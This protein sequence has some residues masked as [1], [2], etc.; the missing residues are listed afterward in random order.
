MAR[1]QVCIGTA[2]FV[3]REVKNFLSK[4]LLLRKGQPQWRSS[5]ENLSHK[6]ENMP[7]VASTLVVNVDQISQEV[8][9]HEKRNCNI[10]VTIV[11][12]GDRKIVENLVN[13]IARSI[14]ISGEIVRLGFGPNTLRIEVWTK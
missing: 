8:S 3:N 1:K 2:G 5:L 9:E 10:I 12:D 4:W 7:A 6:H 11:Q 14:Q 13:K